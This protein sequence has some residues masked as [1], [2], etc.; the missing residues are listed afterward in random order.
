MNR[1]SFLVTAGGVSAGGLAIGGILYSRRDSDGTPVSS[2]DDD[3]TVSR[4]GDD[5]QDREK[6]KI[7]IDFGKHDLDRH[8]SNSVT[9]SHEVFFVCNRGKESASIW[10]EA[11]PIQNSHGEPS[12]RFYADRTLDDRVDAST[13]TQ[14]IEPDDCLPVGVMTRTFGLS[15]DTKL[16]EEIVVRTDRAH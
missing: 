6:S 10:I 9:F 11:D 5:K 7:E 3:T 2:D 4:P 14:T 8:N 15:S 12:V 13:R 1:R 16:L